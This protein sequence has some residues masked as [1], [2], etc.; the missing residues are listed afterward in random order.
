M[1]LS[2]FLMLLFVF[3]TL[4]FVGSRWVAQEVEQPS[5]FCVLGAIWAALGTYFFHCIW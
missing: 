1:T 3:V 5:I 2:Y 4:F